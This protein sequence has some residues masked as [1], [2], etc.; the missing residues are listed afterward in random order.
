MPTIRCDKCDTECSDAAIRD[1]WCENC[2]KRIP[3]YLLQERKKPAA[4]GETE[5]LPPGEVEFHIP[6]QTRLIAFLV[7]FGAS[8]AAWFIPVWTLTHLLAGGHKFGEAIVAAV[9]GSVMGL[10]LT[11]IAAA[12]LRAGRIVVT[13]TE[14]RYTRPFLDA[15][16]PFLVTHVVPYKAVERFGFG[17]TPE[18]TDFFI[19]SKAIPTILL[20][21]N[22][23]VHRLILR[24]YPDPGRIL[25]AIRRRLMTPPESIVPGW[26]GLGKFR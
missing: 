5:S 21:A 4:A 9:F 10:I 20:R 17:F 11:S 19:L 25:A 23:S 13:D 15:L 24:E 12:R 14:V 1:G 22:G 2:G 26:L 7:L 8:I 6:F 16:G 18:D 3:E